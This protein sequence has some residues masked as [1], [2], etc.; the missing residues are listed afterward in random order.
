MVLFDILIL[1]GFG[2]LV[3]LLSTLLGAWMMFRGR[4]ANLGDNFILRNPKGQVFTIPEAEG[5]E[6]FPDAEKNV[7]KKTEEFLKVLGGRS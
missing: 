5:G 1:I 4:T 2:V 3:A 7:L 6:D